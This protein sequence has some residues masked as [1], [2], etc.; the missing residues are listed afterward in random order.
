MTTRRWL[1]LALVAVAVLLIVGRGLAGA[2]ADYL[3]YDAL[4]AVALWRIR[5]MTI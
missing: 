2:Y 4:G 5:L 3:W 1:T